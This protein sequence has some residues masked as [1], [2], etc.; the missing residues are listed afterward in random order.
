MKN[1]GHYKELAM[2]ELKKIHGDS[3]QMVVAYKEIHTI[4]N[5]MIMLDMIAKFEESKAIAE[6]AVVQEPIKPTKEVKKQGK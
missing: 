6:I 1:Y 2:E 3:A 4:T 5:S